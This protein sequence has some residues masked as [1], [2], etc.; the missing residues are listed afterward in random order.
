MGKTLLALDF[1]LSFYVHR[2]SSRRFTFRKVD[3]YIFQ[4]LFLL[5]SVFCSMLELFFFHIQ[6]TA[7]DCNLEL[8]KK[9]KR[10]C[11]GKDTS[12]CEEQTKTKKKKKKK[13]IKSAAEELIENDNINHNE[14]IWKMKK[15]KKKEKFTEEKCEDEIDDSK[16]KKKKKRKLRDDEKEGDND[17]TPEGGNLYPNN[18]K[19]IKQNRENI[20]DTE[21]FDLLNAPSDSNHCKKKKKRKK[22]KPV[23]QEKGIDFENSVDFTIVTENHVSAIR[24]VKKTPIKEYDIEEIQMPSEKPCL[25]KNN[26]LLDI[27]Q[28]IMNDREKLVA[29]SAKSKKKKNKRCE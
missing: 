17:F 13:K 19:V 11:E 27:S 28:D 16:P 3:I 7:G 22:D 9:K 12:D 20:L 10:K 1:F 18:S 5:F 14:I 29:A 6:S 2:T 25:V 24:G 21:N 23:E 4:I 8:K 26:G 15:K